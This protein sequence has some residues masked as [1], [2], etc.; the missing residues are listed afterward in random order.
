MPKNYEE[1]YLMSLK[2]KDIIQKINTKIQ[3]FE[4]NSIKKLKYLKSDI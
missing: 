4:L 3:A 1:C 2:I